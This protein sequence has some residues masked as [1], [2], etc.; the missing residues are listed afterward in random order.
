MKKLNQ[1][2]WST[3][4]ALESVYHNEEWGIPVSDD[5]KHFEMILLE[6]AQAGLSW[7]T[8]LTKRM[9][10]KKAFNNFDFKKVSRFTEKD[11][12]QLLENDGIVRHKQKIVSVINNAQIF[13]EVQKEFGTFN[14][15]IWSFVDFSPINNAWESAGMIPAS[16][17]LSEEI[18][19]NLKERGF[20]FV[21]ATTIYA[22]MQSIGMVNDHVKTCFRYPAMLK[23]QKEFK[24]KRKI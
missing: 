1:C 20:K 3:K 10:Y 18:S 12:E 5:N 17:S 2:A 11:V 8:I 13:I 4:T 15:Y 6:G 7:H 14:N 21:G 23:A 19:K 9:A 16:T 22:Y 24:A